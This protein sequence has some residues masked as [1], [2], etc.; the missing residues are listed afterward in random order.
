M[1]GSNATSEGSAGKSRKNPCK[2]DAAIL[3][4]DHSIGSWIFQPWTRGSALLAAL[5]L[6]HLAVSFLTAPGIVQALHI[7]YREGNLTVHIPLLSSPRTKPY[8]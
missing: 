5:S 6:Y 3:L 7:Y 2:T 1:M 8:S 4:G